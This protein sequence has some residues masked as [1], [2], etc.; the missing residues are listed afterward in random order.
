MDNMEMYNKFR[1]VPDTAKKAIQAGRLKGF[2][3]INPMWRIKMLTEAF[4]MCGIGWYYEVIKE[5]FRDGVDGQI[6][7][8]TDINLYVKVDGEWSKPIFGSGGSMFVT[9][10]SK[11]LYVSDEAKKMSQTDAIGNACKSLGIGADV[12]FE[13]DRTK[14]NGDGDDSDTDEKTLE[15]AIGKMRTSFDMAA[16]TATWQEYP[17][18]GKDEKFI[19][20]CRDAQVRVKNASEKA[21]TNGNA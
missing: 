19:K 4:G 21:S 13:K 8:F 12:Y 3:D 18:F 5:D 15:I 11:G 6:A 9:K 7:I 14:Y 2:T 10:E 17:Q 1:E 20:E 16:I